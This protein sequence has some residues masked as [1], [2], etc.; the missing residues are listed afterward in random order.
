MLTRMCRTCGNPT[1]TK[2]HYCSAACRD[3]A[4][5]KRFGTIIEPMN[6]R[7]EKLMDEMIAEGLAEVREVQR[8]FVQR[9]M[10][11]DDSPQAEVRM[12]RHLDLMRTGV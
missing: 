12:R 5:I 9:F 10:P 4:R 3:N 11:E 8:V 7:E 6:A 2:C 1:G